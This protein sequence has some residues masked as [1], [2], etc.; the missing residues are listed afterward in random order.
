MIMPTILWPLTQLGRDVVNGGA[1]T[2]FAIAHWLVAFAGNSIDNEAVLAAYET[3]IQFRSRSTGLTVPEAFFAAH[4]AGWLPPGTTLRRTHDLTRI[5]YGPIIACYQLRYNSQSATPDGTFINTGSVLGRHT[6]AIIGWDGEHIVFANSWGSHWGDNGLGRMTP[7]QHN[8]A[9]LEMY[10]IVV[11]GHPSTPAEAA[12]A[13]SEAV[14]PELADQ[15]VAVQRNLQALGYP[16]LPT[17]ATIIMPDIIRRSMAGDLT[18]EQERAKS[19]L[20]HIYT[21]L[22]LQGLDDAQINAVHAAKSGG[23]Q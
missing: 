10:Q 4:R 6:V 16:G 17:T 11:P 7:E 22:L 12:K 23:T 14:P 9:I 20:A 8:D 21:M 19:N 1:C 5:V 2:L 15:I 18:P 13:S 3:E